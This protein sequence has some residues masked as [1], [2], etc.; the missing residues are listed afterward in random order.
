MGLHSGK[1]TDY[2]YDEKNHLLKVFRPATVFNRAKQ[3]EAEGMNGEIQ[4]THQ[5]YTLLR[6]HYYLTRRDI[7][8][9]KTEVY[10]LNRKKEI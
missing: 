9:E 6:N 4:T 7:V 2:T 8:S 5:T 10:I 1:F 3:M